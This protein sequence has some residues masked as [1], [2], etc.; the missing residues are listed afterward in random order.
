[1]SNTT[2]STVF[3]GF[4]IASCAGRLAAQEAAPPAVPRRPQEI[5]V[6]GVRPA[7]LM[8][9]FRAADPANGGDVSTALDLLGPY[10]D[11]PNVANADRTVAP[12]LH[13]VARQ[14]ARLP[15]QRRYDL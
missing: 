4:L 12:A 9:F 8:Q 11:N 10:A 15:A 5:R 6:P 2:C 7:T 13:F 1:M 3:A 14:L